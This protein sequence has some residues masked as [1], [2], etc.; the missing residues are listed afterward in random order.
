[1]ELTEENANAKL[2]KKK[3]KMHFVLFYAIKFILIFL[4]KTT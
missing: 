2:L 4:H 1:M 3:H